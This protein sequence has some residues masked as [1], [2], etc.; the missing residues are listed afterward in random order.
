MIKHDET[1][2]N[3]VYDLIIQ[4]I[5]ESQMSE[6]CKWTKRA[7]NIYNS[8]I[9]TFDKLT[10]KVSKHTIAKC[11][12]YVKHIVTIEIIKNIIQTLKEAN[13]EDNS[14]FVISKSRKSL[15]KINYNIFCLIA[16][17]LPVVDLLNVCYINRI[18]HSNIQD[19]RLISKC[20][21][22][23]C[24]RLTSKIVSNY[25]IAFSSQWAYTD[26][27]ELHISIDEDAL[28]ETSVPEFK[29]DTIQYLDA[30][31]FCYPKAL[32]HLKA[33]RIWGTHRPVSKPCEK[34]WV[35]QN[36][37]KSPLILTCI[38]CIHLY[39]GLWIPNCKR[40]LF[41]SCVLNNDVMANFIC[42]KYTKWICI[43]D[44]ELIGPLAESATPSPTADINKYHPN[45]K[46]IY[47][48]TGNWKEIYKLLT[49]NS[50]YDKYVSHFYVIAHYSSLNADLQQLLPVLSNVTNSN[51][52]KKIKMLFEHEGKT[53]EPEGRK[54]KF[55]SP[56][57]KDAFL[58]GFIV[59]QY[60][61]IQCTQS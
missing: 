29:Q 14:E 49:S 40:V 55:F 19:C 21:P 38:T 27:K 1:L 31:K 59:E 52:P 23:K 5:Q 6:L 60:K 54:I 43:Q 61:N 53:L 24:L 34:S 33:L 48:Y 58:W 3:H 13:I 36:D 56:Q 15:D 39:E 57:E 51:E 7:L 9:N 26:L 8:D 47:S 30:C 25:R 10:N 16:T 50:M 45:I 2:G 46:L 28:N 12:I 22:F 37:S 35:I 42:N 41:D 11:L 44:C 17:Y 18:W 32:P 4:S 20:K